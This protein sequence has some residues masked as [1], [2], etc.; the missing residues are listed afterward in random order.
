[1]IATLLC[2]R[3][4]RPKPAPTRVSVGTQLRA[5]RGR[6]ILPGPGSQACTVA[7]TDKTGTARLT[8]RP[9]RAI[10]YTA[11]VDAG[12][13]YGAGVSGRVTVNVKPALVFLSAWQPA[14]GAVLAEV[15]PGTNQLQLQLRNGRSWVSRASTVT[16]P[17]ALFRQASATAPT[18]SSSL[19]RT[20]GS[21]TPDHR[22]DC[23]LASPKTHFATAISC[24]SGSRSATTLRRDLVQPVQL[25]SNSWPRL[26]AAPGGGGCARPSLRARGGS[27]ASHRARGQG[28]AVGDRRVR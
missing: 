23:D 16:T 4:T 24:H 28:Y 25:W 18:G 11:A 19:P 27:P 15:T 2:I 26:R 21:A 10:T 20:A 9:D 7:R 6:S 3:R 1:M 5:K 12:A 17:F 14:G 8:V 22:S 13:D